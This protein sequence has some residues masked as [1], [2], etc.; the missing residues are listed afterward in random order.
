MNLYKKCTIRPYSLL[1]IDTT[2]V[3]DNLLCFRKDLLER[4][5]KLVIA[6]YKIIDEKL[7]YAINKDAAKR[8][9]LFIWKN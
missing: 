7:Q 3:S 8:S 5:Q 2:L 1:V 4:I 9:A 6:D